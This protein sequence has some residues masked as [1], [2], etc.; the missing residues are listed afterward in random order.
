MLQVK[1]EVFVHTRDIVGV[2]VGTFEG[3]AVGTGVGATGTGAEVGL[4]VGA[5]VGTSHA[6]RRSSENEES[7]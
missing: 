6:W 5:A 4:A 7:V 3:A 1:L 2:E